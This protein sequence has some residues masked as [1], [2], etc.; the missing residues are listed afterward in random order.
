MARRR[1]AAFLSSTR[2]TAPQSTPSPAATPITSTACGSASTSTATTRNAGLRLRAGDN[3]PPPC[4]EDRGGGREVTRK[5]GRFIAAR[6][7]RELPPDP[8]PPSPQGGREL[9]LAHVR[10]LYPKRGGEIDLVILLL[11][12]DFADLL[13]QG[14]FAE[15][16][17]LPDTVAIIAHG[18]VLVV[19]IE[20]QHVLGVL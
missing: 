8:T 5:R 9:F 4:G 6:H 13:G 2:Q 3:S 14:K 16:L 7:R 10:H 11:H 1:S 18:L 15:R 12:Q 17:A 20:A 19:E